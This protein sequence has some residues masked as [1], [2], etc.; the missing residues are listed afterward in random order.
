[1]TALLE[2][3]RTKKRETGHRLHV[4]AKHRA[5]ALFG[6]V[7][8]R[9]EGAHARVVDEKRELALVLLDETFELLATVGFGKI[10]RSGANVDAEAF[11][12]FPGH[13]FEH[14]SR[15]GDE[16]QMHAARGELTG[17]L[18]TDPARSAGDEGIGFRHAASFKGVLV[19]CATKISL[20]RRPSWLR[21]PAGGCRTRVRLRPSREDDGV[22]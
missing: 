16:R 5:N 7:Q 10:E 1:M 2:A 11:R 13:F 21:F 17:D 9:T 19:H 4:E 6:N 3:L 14:V 12:K 20:R 15:T 8:G 22:P 18:E